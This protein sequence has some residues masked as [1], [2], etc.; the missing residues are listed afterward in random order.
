MSIKTNKISKRS[1]I[2]SYIALAIWIVVYNL[3]V[4]FDMVHLYKIGVALVITMLILAI[5][6]STAGCFKLFSFVFVSLAISNVIDEMFFDSLVIEWNDIVAT[7]ILTT[8]GFIRYARE[9]KF[10]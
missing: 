5:H 4:E 1:K 10:C 9:T 6:L 8:I 3:K 7:T 2:L